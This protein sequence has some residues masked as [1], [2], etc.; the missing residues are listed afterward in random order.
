MSNVYQNITKK[1]SE[2]SVHVPG[3]VRW[4][5][6]HILV[7]LDGTICEMPEE[8][9]LFNILSAMLSKRE[10]IPV[11]DAMQRILTLFKQD[12]GQ[13]NIRR[14]DLV[15]VEMGFKQEEFDR[16]SVEWLDTNTCQFD[17]ALEML[18][19][20]QGNGFDLCLATNAFGPGIRLRMQRNG[21]LPPA[22]LDVF[23]NLV[24]AAE[25]ASQKFS[26]SPYYPEFGRRHDV[27][28]SQA[29]MIGDNPD[30]DFEKALIQGVGYAILVDRKSDTPIRHVSPRQ[31][32]VNSL[33]IVPSLLCPAVLHNQHDI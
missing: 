33:R 20:L 7:D 1:P 32:V 4:M 12:I 5:V 11:D 8:W 2:V 22:G 24:I 30:E 23:R 25:D 14:F 31:V 26:V 18:R 27:D 15:V 21:M 13:R 28:I 17:D 16:S 6:R 10:N 3:A 9:W 29:V 19:E